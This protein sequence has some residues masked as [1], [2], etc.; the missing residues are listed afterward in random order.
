MHRCLLCRILANLQECS[1]IMTHKDWNPQCRVVDGHWR[2]YPTQCIKWHG[3]SVIMWSCIAAI[4]S[5]CQFRVLVLQVCV[6]VKSIKNRYKANRKKI[7]SSLSG[8]IPHIQNNN[9]LLLEW[10]NSFC[11]WQW[12]PKESMDTYI[13]NTHMLHK[14]LKGYTILMNLFL[15]RLKNINHKDQAGS[16]CC[17]KSLGSKGYFQ[18]NKK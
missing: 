7:S 5:Q 16:E 18:E 9:I 1:L 3:M 15:A 6:T 2:F 8:Q 11:V 4:N 10:A 12:T 17:N 13:A 14:R